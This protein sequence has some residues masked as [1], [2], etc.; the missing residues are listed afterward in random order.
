[1]ASTYD[2]TIASAELASEVPETGKI[3]PSPSGFMCDCA[4][5]KNNHLAV[6][7]APGGMCPHCWAEAPFHRQ[8]LREA[9]ISKGMHPYE[10]SLMDNEDI[11]DFWDIP[12]GYPDDDGYPWEAG[13]AR[14]VPR[15]ADP[16]DLD[17]YVTDWEAAFS[18]QPAEVEWLYQPVLERG[19]ANVI[20]SD[21]GVGKSLV[22]LELA[23]SIARTEVVIYVDSENRTVDHVDRLG[24][25]GYT[26]EKL[27]N[28]IMLSFPQL[29]PLDSRRG[30]E[31]LCAYAR[32]KGAALV[33]IDTTMRFVEGKEND[34]DTFNA[35]YRC[36]MLPL[37]AAGITSLRLDHEGKDSSKGQ[38][39]SSGKRGDVDSVWRLTHPQKGS[40]RWLDNEKTRSNHYPEKIR[41]EIIAEP[42]GHVYH[43]DRDYLAPKRKAEVNP[44]VKLLDDIGLPPDAGR[45]VAQRLLAE[46]KIPMGTARLDAA[47]KARQSTTV[48]VCTQA[49]TGE[50]E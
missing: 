35:M 5:E 4:P 21:A 25:M 31:V 6:T 27:K 37:K 28:L 9:A 19:T 41:L 7:L 42:F 15:E 49:C 39:G 18:R 3:I 47:L 34:S 10:G 22:S 13:P 50:N 17:R 36:T 45:R 8:A 48:D 33:I 40:T 38:R 12:A 20:Y 1:V 26:P 30:G 16:C 29:P 46:K 43:W 44:D 14:D 2:L 24:D 11:P 23:A 32:K